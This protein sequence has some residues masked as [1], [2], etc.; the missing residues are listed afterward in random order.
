MQCKCCN[1]T[2]VRS[3][4]ENMITHSTSGDLCKWLKKFTPMEIGEGS[5]ASVVHADAMEV[6]FK[7]PAQSVDVIWADPPYFI[8]RK[9]GT[10]CRSGKRTSVDKGEWDRTVG[11]L[12]SEHQW[13][14]RW[15]CY[16]QRVLRRSGSIWVCGNYQSLWSIGW[17]MQELGFHVLNCVTWI[18]PNAS[19][20]LSCRML[21]HS[22]EM[23][24]WASPKKTAPQSHVFNYDIAK[25][26]AGG[27][28]MRD[29][30]TVPALIPFAEKKHGKHPT[31]KPEALIERALSISLPEGGTVF[32]PFCGYGS[33][34]PAAIR[35]GAGQWVGVDSDKNACEVSTKRITDVLQG[36]SHERRVWKA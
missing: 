14:R 7:L 28:Q 35:S 11:D 6:L 36:D 9:G 23:I 2:P 8:S 21:T 26:I 19:P 3:I 30:W 31:Q 15:L 10:T 33:S 16:A 27:K 24:L 18:K 12:S 34:A 5:I 17:A 22:T 1:K 32:D 29:F 20:N 13:H 4:L 25:K